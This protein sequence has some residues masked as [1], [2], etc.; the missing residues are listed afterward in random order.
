MTVQYAVP[1]DTKAESVTMRF[2]DVL[3][4]RVATVAGGRHERQLSVT[5]LSSGVYF[6]RL[7]AGERTAT[8]RVVIVR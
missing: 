2:Y 1:E 5:D 3:G 7:Q 6:L 4:R 8:Q